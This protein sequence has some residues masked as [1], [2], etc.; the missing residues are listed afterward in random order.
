M[1]VAPGNNTLDLTGWTG[2]IGSLTVQNGGK[3]TLNGGTFATLNFNDAAAGSLL[4]SG[5]AFQNVG[6]KQLLMKFA[7]LKILK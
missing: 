7:K 6:T 1:I 3:A 2:R 5:Y 4:A